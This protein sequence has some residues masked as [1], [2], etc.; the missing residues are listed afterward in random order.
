MNISKVKTATKIGKFSLRSNSPNKIQLE[1]VVSETLLQN[2][3]PRIYLFVEN[4]IIKKI[5]GSSARGGIK[6]TMSFYVNSMQGS[7]GV[8]RFVLHLLIERSL[9]SG[10]NVD[11]YMITSPIVEAP[12]NG[13]FKTHKMNVASFKEMENRCKEDYFATEN[14]YPEWN[15]QEN[16]TPYPADL[17]RRHNDYHR[18]RL[19]TD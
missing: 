5:G 18:N 10:S 12:V 15:F 7:P 14:R 16:A 6:A 9:K 3:A 8:P 11:L 2:E 1:Y 17:A 13:L 4:N 19:A